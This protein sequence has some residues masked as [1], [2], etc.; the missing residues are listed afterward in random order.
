MITI[1][2]KNCNNIL[3]VQDF[4]KYVTKWFLLIAQLLLWTF[5]P[6]SS[7]SLSALESATFN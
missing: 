4:R 2:K 6:D 3:E 7:L 5:S 1:I